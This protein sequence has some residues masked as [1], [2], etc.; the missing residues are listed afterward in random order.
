MDL[1]HDKVWEGTSHAEGAYVKSWADLLYRLTEP[2]SHDHEVYLT[3]LLDLFYV[4]N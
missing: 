2:K 3:D 1:V 4:V